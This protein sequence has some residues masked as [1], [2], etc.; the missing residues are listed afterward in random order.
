[1]S[2][3]TNAAKLQARRK[4]AHRRGRKNLAFG[5][6]PVFIA[7]PSLFQDPTLL[8]HI[9]GFILRTLELHTPH[10]GPGMGD[11]PGDTFIMPEGITP[12][13]EVQ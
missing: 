3:K 4:N 7:G 8:H 12:E 5:Q 10:T 2:K 1:M 13:S 9:V 6:P 11:H